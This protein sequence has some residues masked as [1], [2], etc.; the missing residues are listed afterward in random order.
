EG[1][2]DDLP[3][4][5]RELELKFTSPET[6]EIRDKATDTVLAERAYDF[7]G[8]IHYQGIAISLSGSPVSGDVFS[9]SANKGGIGGTGNLARM[10]QLEEADIFD[11]DQTLQQGYLSLLN[12]A[13][14]IS[15]QADVARQALEVLK[16]QAVESRES[17]AGVNLDEEAASLIRFQQSYQASARLVQAANEL[18]ETIVRL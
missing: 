4:F 8:Q 6:F 13:G 11:G 18:F 7:S 12:K 3:L 14:T 17:L 10:S 5:D 1:E 2:A 16:D 15:K 9:I